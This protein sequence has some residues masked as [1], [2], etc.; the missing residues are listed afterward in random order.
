[1][2]GLI[3]DLVYLLCFAASAVCAG[4]L[5]RQ[6]RQVPS[7]VLLWSA[8]CF[9]LL[10]V[11]NLLVVIDRVVLPEVDLKLA[12]LGMTLAAVCVLLFGFIWE[13]E[14]D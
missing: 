2:N 8:A 9:V 7:P 3:P 4:L 10:A 11:S 1:M 12:R 13:T 14:Q 5:L 6:Y